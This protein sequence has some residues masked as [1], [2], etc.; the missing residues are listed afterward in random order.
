M[1]AATSVAALAE[2]SKE[3]DLPSIDLCLR[4]HVLLRPLH[5]DDEDRV[6]LVVPPSTRVDVDVVD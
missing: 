2:F 4:L 6:A 3:A 5:L 1:V